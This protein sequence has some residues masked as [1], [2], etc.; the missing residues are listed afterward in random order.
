LLDEKT[1]PAEPIG[2]VLTGP[3]QGLILSIGNDYFLLAAVSLSFFSLAKLSFKVVDNMHADGVLPVPLKTEETN[4]FPTI[5]SFEIKYK[6][7]KHENK[8]SNVINI[9]ID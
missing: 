7:S 1:A 6:N 3:R 8:N 2:L 9:N 4:R 5:F